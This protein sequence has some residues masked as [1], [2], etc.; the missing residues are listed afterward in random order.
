[1]VTDD[2]MKKAQQHLT[3][4]PGVIETKVLSKEDRIAIEMIEKSMEKELVLGLGYCDHQGVTA[5]LQ[6]DIVFCLITNMDYVWPSGSNVIITWEDRIIGGEVTDE[7]HREYLQNQPNTILKGSFVLYKD[8]LPKGSELK[9]KP[10]TIVFPPKP[11]DVLNEI[12][13]ITDAIFASPSRAA[14]T[15]MKNQMG[16]PFDEQGLGTAIIAFNLDGNELS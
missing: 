2:I 9:K 6:R 11:Y 7:S 8:Q 13:G 5:S 14:D 10:C 1:M 12:P 3:N 15:Y 16:F 4:L